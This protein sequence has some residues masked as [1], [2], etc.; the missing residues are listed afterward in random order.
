[1]PD[2]AITNERE[3]TDALFEYANKENINLIIIKE[4]MN[5]EFTIDGVEYTA[6]RYHARYGVTWIQCNRK[7]REIKG[8]GVTEE[9]KL[10]LWILQKYGW[11]IGLLAVFCIW[12][13]PA[14]QKDGMGLES[15]L[16][17]LGWGVFL[18]IAIYRDVVLH[19][20]D[21]TT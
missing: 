20:N 3:F 14:M 19:F 7:N 18:G 5:P 8:E 17:L 16:L 4:S 13:I 2:I 9:R 11:A 1:V 21:K 6:M 10:L 12:G 15:I